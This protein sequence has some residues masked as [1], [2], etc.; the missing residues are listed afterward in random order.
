MPM[1]I[2]WYDD[3]QTIILCTGE[4]HWTWE[5][6]H[7]GSVC[8]VEMISTVNHRVD[9]IYD[10][11]SGSYPPRG[12]GLPHYKQ[13]YQRMPEHAGMH[14]FVGAMSM[15]IQVTM[16]LFFRIYGRTVDPELAGR[17]VV[18][19]SVEAAIALIEKDRASVA[20]PANS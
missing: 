14:V 9:L 10:R 7:D 5:D 4:G 15:I 13:A 3:E 1:H 18:A 11:K 6:F 17:F 12:N 20:V 8:A 2:S 16:N 19:D